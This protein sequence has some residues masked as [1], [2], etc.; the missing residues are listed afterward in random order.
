MDFERGAV[1]GNYQIEERLGQGGQSQVYRA[2]DLSLKRTVA[3]KFLSDTHLDDDTSRKRFLLEA[4]AL[5]ALNHPNIATVFHIGEHGDVPFIVMEYVEGPTLTHFLRARPLSTSDKLRLMIQITAAVEEAHRQGILHRDL[6]PGNILTDRDGRVKLVDFGLAKVTRGVL[7]DRLEQADDFTATGN[8]I[9]TVSYLSPEQARS[10]PVDERSDLFSLGVIFYEMLS[11]ARPFEG[12][13]PLATIVAIANEAPREL[14]RE[15]N[16]PAPLRQ[17]IETLLA[18]DREAR[19]ASAGE[20]LADLRALADE[21][22]RADTTIRRAAI[23]LRRRRRRLALIAAGAALAAAAAVGAWFLWLRPPPRPA[24]GPLTLFVLPIQGSGDDGSRPLAGVVTGELISALNRSPDLRVLSLPEGRRFESSAR[25]AELFREQGVQFVIDGTLL[26]TGDRVIATVKM[27]DAADGSVRWSEN[28]QG[29]INAIFDIPARIAVGA[30]R[31]AGI[32]VEAAKLPFPGREAF[33]AYT[34]GCLLLGAYDPDQLEPAIASL[35]RCIEIAPDFTP[36]YERTVFAYLQYRNLGR[37]YDPAYMDEAE[38][39]IRLGQSR[40]ASSAELLSARLAYHLYTYDLGAA[41][42]DVATAGAGRD[43]VLQ[44]WAHLFHGRTAAAL[45]SY[46]QARIRAPLDGRPLLNQVVVGTMLGDAALV[47]DAYHKLPDV[48]TSGLTRNI[49]EGWWRMS[50]RDT[51]GAVRV[52]EEGFNRYRFHLLILCAAE[53]AYAGGDPAT[54][55]RH[56]DTWLNKNPYAMEGHWLRALARRRMGDSNGAAAAAREG[57]RHA[58]GLAE[59]YPHNPL[60]KLYRIYFQVLAGEFK[61]TAADLPALD[62][63]RADTNS[64]YLH[65]V[66]RARLGDRTAMGGAPVPYNPTYWLNLFSRDELAE[67]ER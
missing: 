2:L 8:I 1:V 51:A 33:D 34:R 7:R 29:D 16:V 44:G 17:V 26:Q 36:A 9:G 22:T 55:A 58:V 23:R 38:R 57:A 53:A 50:R 3:I 45:D 48:Y 61:G 41:G 67:L 32:Y 37:D 25:Q 47:E 5:S 52:L 43:L 59:H 28:I 30:A 42:E 14:P 62:A 21:D 60:L 18:K 63:A 65:A 20:L 49:I 64:R 40:N 54:A 15:A 10:E 46:R 31:A 35:R 11:G 13:S 39:F 6:K 19:Y 24:G 56:L 4:Q 12:P 66:I 27:T